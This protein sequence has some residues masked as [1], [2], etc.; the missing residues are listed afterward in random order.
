MKD[1]ADFYLAVIVLIV[2]LVFTNYFMALGIELFF[3]L[4]F[5]LFYLSLISLLILIIYVILIDK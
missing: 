4:M 5:S 2:L 3:A 1:M